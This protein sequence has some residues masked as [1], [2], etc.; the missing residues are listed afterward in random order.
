[1]YILK[2]S[3]GSYYIGHTNNI[4]ERLIRHNT[5]QGAKWTACRLPVKLVY[6]EIFS[7]ELQAIKRERQIKRWSHQKKEALISGNFK[8]LKVLS[9]SRN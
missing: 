4:Q 3:D 6:K 1:V 2:C 8:T 7:T 5:G 9:K